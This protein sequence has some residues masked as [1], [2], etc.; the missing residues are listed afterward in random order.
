MVAR[1][2]EAVGVDESMFLNCE[3]K[4]RVIMMEWCEYPSGW[5]ESNEANEPLDSVSTV[6]VLGKTYL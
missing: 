4:P 3:A 5:I 6:L 2:G 1:L